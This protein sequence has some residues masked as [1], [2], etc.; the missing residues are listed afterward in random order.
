LVEAIAAAA[1][2]AAVVV[3]EVVVVVMEVGC[4]KQVV[5]TRYWLVP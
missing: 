2:A 4:T 1:A 5:M 3:V